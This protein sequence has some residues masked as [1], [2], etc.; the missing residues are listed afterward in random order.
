MTLVSI[1]FHV[2]IRFEDVF[3]CIICHVAAAAV[4]VA[5]R[6]H[7]SE[8]LD[9]INEDSPDKRFLSLCEPAYLCDHHGTP[10]A[11]RCWSDIKVQALHVLVTN[12]YVQ[13]LLGCSEP[14]AR[15]DEQLTLHALSLIRRS[16]RL[17]TLHIAQS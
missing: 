1:V 5:M 12:S 13:P 10:F 9:M 6:W 3:R 11:D 16:A 14:A 7:V 17:D 2:V 15:R 8:T 4:I